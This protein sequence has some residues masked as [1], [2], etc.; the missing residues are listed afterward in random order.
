MGNLWCK[1][2][3]NGVIPESVG[4][5]SKAESKFHPIP[6][7]DPTA[8]TDQ[9]GESGYWHQHLPHCKL[10]FTPSV[11]E[12]I[13]TEFFI[14]RKDAAAALDVISK[15]GDRA[16]SNLLSRIW[17]IDAN[18]APALYPQPPSKKF[19]FRKTIAFLFGY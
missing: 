4:G 3:D 7:V 2:R 12:E 5:I 6:S 9:F 15:L 18:N 8:C 1:F 16:L 17:C 13:Q 10:E 14:D 11:G 19:G